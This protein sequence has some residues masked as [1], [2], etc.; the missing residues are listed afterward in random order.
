MARQVKFPNFVGVS[1][2]DE[3]LER[4]KVLAEM[5]KSTVSQQ[6]RQLVAE[7]FRKEEE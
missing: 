6:I 1:L 7:V 4:L 5:N 2:D 3:T